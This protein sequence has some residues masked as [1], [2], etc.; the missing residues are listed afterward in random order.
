[1]SV[2]SN[3]QFAKAVSFL[4]SIEDTEWEVSHRAGDNE[5]LWAFGTRDWIIQSIPLSRSKQL[6][7]MTVSNVLSESE[8]VGMA[9]IP[10][11][12]S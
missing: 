9:D 6:S 7:R 4:K 12:L 5:S 2:D 11:S 3:K 1:M 8:R 10:F